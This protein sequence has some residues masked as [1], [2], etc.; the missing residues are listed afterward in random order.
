M[1]NVFK[2]LFRGYTLRTGKLKSAY[3]KICRPDGLEF[4]LLAKRHAGLHAVG[5]DV[6][7]T[8]D[9][10]I[11]D[12]AY[13]RIGNNCTLSDCTLLGHDGVIRILNNAYGKKLDRT[14][15]S[16]LAGAHFYGE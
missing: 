13:V 11:T 15:T 14:R 3:L 6:F 9:A 12:P 10:S 16:A 5:N 4:A 7:I 2:D 8:V 1:L